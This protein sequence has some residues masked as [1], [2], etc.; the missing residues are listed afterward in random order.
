MSQDNSCYKIGPTQ[1]PETP[2]ET[3]SHYVIMTSGYIVTAGMGGGG[4]GGGNPAGWKPK[5]PEDERY[6]G[7]PGE[8]KRDGYKETKIGEDGRASKERHNADHGTPNKHS[9][10]HDHDINWN[11]DGS[12]RHGSPINYP[13]DAP[14]FK[15]FKVVNKLLKEQKG[16]FKY[17]SEFVESLQ[18]NEIQFTYNDK[19]Y[20]ITV[21]GDNGERLI[22]RV[23]D[24]ASEK[25]YPSPNDVMNYIIDGKRLGD[26]VEELTIIL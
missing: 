24:E 17:E 16:Y 14:E 6:L 11:P 19:T 13:G 21:A 8:I 12:P 7:K 4:G 15:S 3:N 23:N 10:P 5:K 25:Q 2:Q 26:I 20:W 1:L 18:W 9:N 22:Y